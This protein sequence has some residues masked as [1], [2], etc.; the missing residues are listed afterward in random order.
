MDSPFSGLGQRFRSPGFRLACGRAPPVCLARP[1]GGR[2]GLREPAE[3]VP[4]Q[5]STEGKVE[6]LNRLPS[7]AFDFV[8]FVGIV[9]VAFWARGKRQLMWQ[10]RLA[11]AA[12]GGGRGNGGDAIAT[13]GGRNALYPFRYAEGEDD[14]RRMSIIQRR[15][16]RGD[17][18]R[19]RCARSGGGRR[20]SGGGR[21]SA[22]K[23]EGGGGYRSARDDSRVGF[24]R[25]RAK[26]KWGMRPR[27]SVAAGTHYSRW[28][29]GPCGGPSVLNSKFL[30]QTCPDVPPRRCR[31]STQETAP[32]IRRLVGKHHAVV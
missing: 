11:V 29:D 14:G 4:P 23:R 17:W 15:R 24:V 25:I 7:T 19:G 2:A 32:S 6:K 8:D 20:G 16:G 12:I 18:P 28:A 22:G 3:A 1:G 21:R 5:E 27:S 13:P 31:I 26:G 30:V 10:R 9:E